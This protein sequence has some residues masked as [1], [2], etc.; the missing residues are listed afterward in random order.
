MRNGSV[1]PDWNSDMDNSLYVINFKTG[2]KVMLSP[3]EAAA[4]KKYVANYKEKLRSFGTVVR[5]TRESGV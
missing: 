2:K 4:K 5:E 1:H 3:E